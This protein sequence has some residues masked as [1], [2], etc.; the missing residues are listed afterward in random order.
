[1]S[2]VRPVP[3]ILG[4]SKKQDL[5]PYPALF[6]QERK[7]NGNVGEPFSLLDIS[8]SLLLT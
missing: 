3:F 4:K 7:V 1:M 8:H 6:G 2:N 5:I